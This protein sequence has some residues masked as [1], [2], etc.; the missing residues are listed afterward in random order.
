MNITFFVLR[1]ECLRRGDDNKAV[2]MMAVLSNEQVKVKLEVHLM[3]KVRGNIVKKIIGAAGTLV[4]LYLCAVIIRQLAIVPRLLV[5]LNS[6]SVKGYESV[7]AMSSWMEECVNWSV[8]LLAA[9]LM[10][11]FWKRSSVSKGILVKG[12]PSKIKL[13]LA[14]LIIIPFTV[15][16]ADPLFT[17]ASPLTSIFALPGNFITE[18]VS[19]SGS[20]VFLTPLTEVSMPWSFASVY[21]DAFSYRLLPFAHLIPFYMLR[22]YCFFWVFKSAYSFRFLLKAKTPKSDFAVSMPL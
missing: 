12:S 8:S 5:A 9:Y 19:K 18:T 10:Y 6:E 4:I 15:Y 16:F 14:I 7:L 13:V 20:M 22:M 3:N 11:G 17:W 21:G 2:K 1:P